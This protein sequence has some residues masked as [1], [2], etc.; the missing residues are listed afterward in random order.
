MLFITGEGFLMDAVGWLP[1]SALQMERLQ[2]DKK[3]LPDPRSTARGG[4]DRT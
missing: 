1:A 2:E 4:E 3:L